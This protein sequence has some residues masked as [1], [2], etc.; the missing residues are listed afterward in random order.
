MVL[1]QY[2][3]MTFEQFDA[4]VFKVWLRAMA[5]IGLVSPLFVPESYLLIVSAACGCFVVFDLVRL[6]R[7]LRR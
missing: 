7:R 4:L 2:R 1:L 3:A 6:R 5:L